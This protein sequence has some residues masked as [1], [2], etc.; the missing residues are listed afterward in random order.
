ML[1]LSKYIACRTKFSP[2]GYQS[3]NTQFDNLLRRYYTRI[4]N[5]A[6]FFKRLENFLS[7]T[8][9]LLNRFLIIYDFVIIMKTMR[10][11][12]NF[13]LLYRTNIYKFGALYVFKIINN[14][15]IPLLVSVFN[16]LAIKDLDIKNRHR[17]F[18]VQRLVIVNAFQR[19][20]H[21]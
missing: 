5:F 3:S 10:I 21:G 11:F 19:Q 6:C 16:T 1:F 8:C 7:L 15:R 9:A 20:M 4:D 13:Y 18:M 12:L 17:H 14:D 2:V